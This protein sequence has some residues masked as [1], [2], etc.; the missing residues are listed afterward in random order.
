MTTNDLY[1]GHTYKTDDTTVFV[2]ETAANYVVLEY[3]DPESVEFRRS[4]GRSVKAK[5]YKANHKDEVYE[6]VH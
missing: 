2:H 6:L 3:T 4:L 1:V 5:V